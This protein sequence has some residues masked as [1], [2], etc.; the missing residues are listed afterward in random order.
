MISS[1]FI[2][3]I[4]AAYIVAALLTAIVSYK[5]VIPAGLSELPPA[6]LDKPA[7]AALT[8]ST[9]LIK[10]LMTLATAL[11]PVCV[12]LLTRPLTNSTELVERSVW[13]ALTILALCLSLYFGFIALNRALVMAALKGFDPRLDFV[14]WPQAMQYYSFVSGAALLGFGCIRSLNA[15]LE[16]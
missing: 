4:S 1:R 12:W 11:V 9:D 7:N 2:N 13:S 15:I 8:L 10:L 16:R 5:V 6:N 14:W 3:I